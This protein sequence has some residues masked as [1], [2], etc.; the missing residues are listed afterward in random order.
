MDVLGSRAKVCTELH[1]VSGGHGVQL[2]D[3]RL[4]GFL[5]VVKQGHVVTGDLY[6]SIL[7]EGR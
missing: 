5:S 1:L 4:H 6:I 7:L 3:Q 2:G